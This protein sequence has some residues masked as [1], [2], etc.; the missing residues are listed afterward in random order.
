MPR[1]TIHTCTSLNGLCQYKWTPPEPF[2]LPI[3]TLTFSACQPEGECWSATKI[4]AI[5]GAWSFSFSL[6][7]LWATLW[8]LKDYRW[9]FVFS[10]QIPCGAFLSVLLPADK[11]N[12][13]FS[14]SSNLIIRSVICINWPIHLVVFL[15]SKLYMWFH[16]IAN[17][18]FLELTEMFQNT[19]VEKLR[20]A[21]LRWKQHISQK[22][23]L[24]R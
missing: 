23:N 12:V 13:W 1:P 22:P 5:Y 6:G 8:G 14:V 24:G 2:N 17:K 20:Y 11:H 3:L 15:Y 18:L 16:F 9:W 10:A 4:N 21:K 19:I 7:T